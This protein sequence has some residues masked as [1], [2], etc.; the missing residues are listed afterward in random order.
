MPPLLRCGSFHLLP[1]LQG[2]LR[3]PFNGNI[4]AR[5]ECAKDFCDRCAYFGNEVYTPPV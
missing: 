2:E 5:V 3:Q 4:F 1:D